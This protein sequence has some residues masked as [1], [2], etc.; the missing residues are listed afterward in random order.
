MRQ[1]NVDRVAI[2]W[3]EG[4]TR[5]GLAVILKEQNGDRSVPIWYGWAEGQALLFGLQGLR[6]QRPMAHDLLDTIIREMGG[7][8]EGVVVSAL[9][10]N[11]FHGTLRITIGE[12]AIEIDCRPSDGIALAARSSS[13]LY[14]DESVL[15]A[16]G[17]KDLT[18]FGPF[19]MIW[20][21]VD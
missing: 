21:V 12:K 14:V 9:E 10:E 11:V 16:A 8:V 1:V 18:K 7:K 2:T 13:P 5:G 4:N 17:K 19:S 3:G 6:L 20:P 15:D